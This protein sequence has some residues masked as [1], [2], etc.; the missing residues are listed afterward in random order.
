MDYWKEYR[1]YGLWDEFVLSGSIGWFPKETTFSELQ[2][3]GRK[4]I[5]TSVEIQ[6]ETL[7]DHV[8]NYI[9]IN[10]INNDAWNARTR[11]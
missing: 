9:K 11:P 4:R 7:R 8:N 2:E 6:L 3:K 10:D 5:E 1:D